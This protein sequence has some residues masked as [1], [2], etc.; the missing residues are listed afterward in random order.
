MRF[1]DLTVQPVY[2]KQQA[3]ITWS[4]DQDMEGARFTVLKSVDESI[5]LEI[6]QVEGVTQF[7]DPHFTIRD[8]LTVF[9]YKIR[10]EK[11]GKVVESDSVGTFGKATREEF[12]VANVILQQW[13]RKL[14]QSTAV[15]VRKQL[16]YAPVCTVC[17]DPDTGQK[18]SSSMCLS[19]FGTGRLGG[20]GCPIPSFMSLKD[21]PGRKTAADPT[22]AGELDTQQFKAVMLAF[23]SLRQGDLIVDTGSDDRYLVNSLDTY[24]VYGKLTILYTVDLSL[25]ARND[26]RYK[27]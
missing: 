26:V 19:C 23:P 17:T 25:L 5:W 13:G 2:G 8:R 7:L 22:G 9:F 4:V 3:A 12:G 16:L 10:A 6:G 27:V 24:D 11:A 21:T 1:K 15:V 20:F 18:L 14:Q